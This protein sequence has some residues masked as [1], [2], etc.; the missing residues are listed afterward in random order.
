MRMTQPRPVEPGVRQSSVQAPARPQWWPRLLDGPHP[1]GSFDATVGRYGV[2]HYGLIV[3][4]P[5]TTTADR[6]LARIW[7]GWP[8]AG[9]A[10]GLLAVILL[11]DTAAPPATVLE[12][13]V[14]AYVGIGALLFLRGGPVRVHVRS[15]SAILLPG[16]ADA[17]ERRKHTEWAVVVS[18]LTQADRAVADG[19]ISLVDY[20]AIWW[21]AYDRV[22][23]ITRV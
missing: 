8:T 13:A 12:Y 19:A 21:A 5:G 20:E 11:G 2:R 6:R 22:S 10:L 4:P 9:G 18:M 16:N 7:R 17:D 1:W 14:A 15:L 3:Y 23:A